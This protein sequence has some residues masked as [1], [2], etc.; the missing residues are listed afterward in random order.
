[1][2]WGARMCVISYR[3]HDRV[4]GRAKQVSITVLW[5][6]YK[7]ICSARISDFLSF[8]DIYVQSMLNLFDRLSSYS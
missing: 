3:N 8:L 6:I 1:M 7:K 4:K 5:K 2:S